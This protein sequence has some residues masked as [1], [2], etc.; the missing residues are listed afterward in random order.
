MSDF[1]LC[2]VPLFVAVDVLG[3][4]PIFL[5]MTHGMEAP[6]VR[7]IVYRS[8]AT[9]LA[10]ALVFAAA[11]PQLLHLLGITVTDFRVAGGTLLLALAVRELVVDKEPHRGEMIA[12]GAVPLGV[13]LITGPAVL[14]T[15]ILLVDR[16]GLLSTSAAIVA[17][18]LIAGLVFRSG[19]TLRHY[20][21]SAGSTI[22]SKVANLFLAAIGVMMIR[23]GIET[24][25]TTGVAPR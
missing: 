8:V 22:A 14:T 5:A 24:L 6:D 17:N 18:M 13:P 16:Y 11:G 7:R 23:Q 4:L 10:I 15:S 3:V 20:L 19:G 25:L 12:L 21:G 9:A 2:F 1:W